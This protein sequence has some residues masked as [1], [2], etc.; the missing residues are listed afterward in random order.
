MFPLGLTCSLP[1]IQLR[2]AKASTWHT[3]ST[4]TRCFA[5][6]YRLQEDYVWTEMFLNRM[7]TNNKILPIEP[8][9]VEM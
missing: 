5:F 3:S 7:V 4:L 8:Q 1:D 2:W 6:A 9:E